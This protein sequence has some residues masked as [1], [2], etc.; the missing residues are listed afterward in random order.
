MEKHEVSSK[1][2]EE[3]MK[4]KPKSMR[5]SKQDALAASMEALTVSHGP[6]AMEPTIAED[7]H[8]EPSEEGV[9]RDLEEDFTGEARMPRALGEAGEPRARNVNP[10]LAALSRPGAPASIRTP[11]MGPP[12]RGPSDEPLYQVVGDAL[13]ERAR[14]QLE[15]RHQWDQAVEEAVVEVETAFNRMAAAETQLSAEQ[16]AE[17]ARRLMQ[18]S[19]TFLERLQGEGLVS[20]G[21]E[22]VARLQ[23]RR[24]TTMD[25]ISYLQQELEVVRTGYEDEVAYLKAQSIRRLA[26]EKAKLEQQFRDGVEEA[27]LHR[28][29]SYCPRPTVVVETEGGQPKAMA[30]PDRARGGIGVPSTGS[31][32]F[33]PLRQEARNQ[34]AFGRMGERDG[35]IAPSGELS[36]LRRALISEGYA[37]AS[38][39]K[40]G[41][42][43]AQET[44]F[45]LPRRTEDGSRHVQL[46][47]TWI[48]PCIS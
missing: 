13:L 32:L 42:R 38:A 33:A 29:T 10:F 36:A 12:G 23:E 19:A 28:R 8:L 31:S 35:A 24:S 37:S 2:L 14:T 40:T 21:T 3:N 15:R 26:E 6:R 1:E 9:R 39:S 17:L 25:E 11:V 34:V 22:R 5:D 18:T 48:S 46:N 44:R 45:G 7:Q 43:G 47:K 41:S 30:T 20:P 4:G 27:S 16:Q